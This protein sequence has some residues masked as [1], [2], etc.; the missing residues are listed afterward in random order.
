MYICGCFAYI[1]YEGK[2]QGCHSERPSQ[3]GGV[4]QQEPYEIQWGQMQSPASGKEET[5]AEIQAET[6]WWGW[7]L[8]ESSMGWR[9]PQGW[10]AEAKS[11]PVLSLPSHMGHISVELVMG[12]SNSLQHDKWWTRAIAKSKRRQDQRQSWRRVQL[13][14]DSGLEGDPGKGECV[15]VPVEYEQD[16]YVFASPRALT[17]LS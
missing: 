17:Q 11:D 5:L 15:V 4:G 8:S 13:Q 9:L 16:C 10:G 3:V 14:S 6:S 1:Y 12:F 7:N 2:W